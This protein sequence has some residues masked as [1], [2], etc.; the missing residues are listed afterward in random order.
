MST[1][2][3]YKPLTCARI[4]GIKAPLVSEGGD[5]GCRRDKKVRIQLSH[6]PVDVRAD[7]Y[8]ETHG[9]HV[10]NVVW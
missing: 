4:K 10:T 9:V 8:A 6:S 2:S 3:T 5:S 1:K 7:P